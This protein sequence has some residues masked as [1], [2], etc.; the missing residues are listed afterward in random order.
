M[1]WADDPDALDHARAVADELVA[2]RLARRA[3]SPP[4]TLELTPFG[5]YWSA[6]GGYFAFLKDD[7]A[8]AATRS[9]ARGGDEDG[10][11]PAIRRELQ[12]L[13]LNLTRKRLRTFWWGF[14]ISI[15]SLVVSLFS[16]YLA[17][18]GGR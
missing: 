7:G 18:T 5:R 6:H 15:V 13:R 2:L 14:G 11:D 17:V 3:D 12:M 9:G 16:L 4:T 8:P 10:G 1:E